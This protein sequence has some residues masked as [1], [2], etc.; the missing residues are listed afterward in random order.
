M[1]SNSYFDS[2]IAAKNGTETISGFASV[3]GTAA[4]FTT[5][6]FTG[7]LK[8]TSH[9]KIGAGDGCKYLFNGSLATQASIVAA[10]QALAD[11]SAS[12]KGSMYFAESN[13]WIFTASVLATPITVP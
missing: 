12:L 7:A 10:A 13:P 4:A 6:T 5:G 3:G 2:N 1:P 11:V 8:T 9:I